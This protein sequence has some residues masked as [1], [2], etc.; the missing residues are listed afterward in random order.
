MEKKIKEVISRLRFEVAHSEDEWGSAEE[1]VLKDP[2]FYVK[3]QVTESATI[4]E[5][6]DRGGWIVVGMSMLNR[7]PMDRIVSTMVGM[8]EMCKDEVKK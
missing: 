2:D 3:I 6:I 4:F 7:W 5:F 1:V 8:I